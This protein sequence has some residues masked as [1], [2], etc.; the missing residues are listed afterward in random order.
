MAHE[1]LE[2]FYIQSGLLCVGTEGMP[3]H[4]RGHTG[5][6]IFTVKGNELPLQNSHVIL[7]VH[8]DLGFPALSKNK[9]PE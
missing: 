4:M 9:N 6:N 1:V 5:E 7:Q 3:Q 2:T 8:G